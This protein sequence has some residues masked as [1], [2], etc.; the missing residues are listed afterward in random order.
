MSAR[1]ADKLESLITAAISAR[2]VAARRDLFCSPDGLKLVRAA[3]DLFEVDG[4]FDLAND[5]AR[6]IEPSEVRAA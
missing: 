3:F 4:L 2:G 5:V 1:Q 6:E